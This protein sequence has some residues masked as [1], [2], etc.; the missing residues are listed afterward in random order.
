MDALAQI[1]AAQKVAGPETVIVF[2]FMP[3]RCCVPGSGYTPVG[4]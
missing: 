4:Y 1:S 2:L 3:I